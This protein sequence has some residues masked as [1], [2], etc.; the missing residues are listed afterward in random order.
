M[1]RERQ[2]FALSMG[3]RTVRFVFHLDVSD[4]HVDGLISAL[5]TI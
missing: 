3:G 2:V 1:L 4:S 5:R